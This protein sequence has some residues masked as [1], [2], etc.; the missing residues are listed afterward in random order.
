MLDLP[1]CAVLSVTLHGRVEL[2][3]AS[4]GKVIRVGFICMRI[5]IIIPVYIFIDL[6]NYNKLLSLLIP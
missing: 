3:I 1:V 2:Q 5:I 6:S 4:P